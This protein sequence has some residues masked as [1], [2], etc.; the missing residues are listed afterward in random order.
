VGGGLMLEW[1]PAR[2]HKPASAVVVQRSADAR[3]WRRQWAV[4]L[5][6][7]EGGAEFGRAGR[8]LAHDR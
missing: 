2:G 4:T 7:A 8:S 3:A 1:W 6:R 5:S